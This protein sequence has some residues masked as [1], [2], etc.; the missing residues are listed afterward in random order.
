MAYFC[1]SS[2]RIF[3][4]IMTF[5][6]CQLLTFFLLII[7]D[8]L[9]RN[10]SLIFCQLLILFLLVIWENLPR[11]LSWWLLLLCLLLLPV[12][13]PEIQQILCNCNCNFKKKYLPLTYICSGDWP[14]LVLITDFLKSRLEYSKL[15]LTLRCL[16]PYPRCP[17]QHGK[18]V[19]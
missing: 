6:I 14:F 18:I 9:P 5:I 4:V 2:E 11:V 15:K 17:G 1:W 19:S 16:K 13:S 8:Y 10:M 3:H 12:E 7:W